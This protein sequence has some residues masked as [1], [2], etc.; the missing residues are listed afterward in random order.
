MEVEQGGGHG[1]NK[2][3]RISRQGL[4]QTKKGQ[5][6]GN[7][8]YPKCTWNPLEGFKNLGCQDMTRVPSGNEEEFLL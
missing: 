2:E 1:G 7:G 4:G 5:V 8:S 3:G 6:K